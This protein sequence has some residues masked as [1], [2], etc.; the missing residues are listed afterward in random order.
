ME[1][2]FTK[3]RKFS[4]DLDTNL[5][6]I[7][8]L[9]QTNNFYIDNNDNDNDNDNDN[10]DNNDNNI[11]YIDNIED[12]IPDYV[13]EHIPDK[14]LNSEK[15]NINVCGK[16]DDETKNPN[17][18]P[19]NKR[20][21]RNKNKNP[22]KTDKPTY[23]EKD[24][25][26]I[27]DD[28][29]NRTDRDKGDKDKGEQTD[30][31]NKTNQTD[32]T[33][34][35]SNSSRT[36]YSTYTNTNKRSRFEPQQNLNQEQD[37]AEYESYYEDYINSQNKICTNPTCDHTLHIESWYDEHKITISTVNT[38]DDLIFLG[39]FYHC[40]MRVEYNGIDMKILHS[41]KEPLIELN[42]MIGLGKIKEEIVNTII[43][44][45]LTKNLSKEINSDMM[46]AV[47]TGSPGCGKTTFIEILAKVYIGLGVLKK[48][49]IVKTRRSELIGKYLGHTAVQ[50]QKKIEEAHGGILL[51]DEAYALGNP[52]GKD[53]FAKECLDTLNQALSEQKTEFICIIA[54]YKDALDSSFFKYNEGLKRR[55][56]FRYEIEKYTS[57]ELSMI[58]LKKI[59]E[60]GHYGVHKNS[61]W[62]IEFT[63]KQ[64]QNLIKD[65][66]KHFVNQGGDMETLF[67]GAKI[68]QNK[69]VF[70]LEVEEKKKL[71]LSDIKTSVDKFMLLHKLKDSRDDYVLNTMYI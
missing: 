21:K 36:Y 16:S 70:L 17:E 25:R 43:Y 69:R 34:Q 18:R 27:Q 10:N 62:K 47:I 42:N 46:H 23:T 6:E 40:M 65:N 9:M 68:A 26:G 24:N 12:Y 64:L 60:Y 38:L 66:Y 32:K 33:E 1:N 29:P 52:E 41:L 28:K 45:L 22:P 71:L 13:Q 55:F 20:D 35:P 53:S 3:K 57:D 14:E 19:P 44:F 2:T 5:E 31:T 8:H 54:G 58:L 56:P 48:G 4:L 51:I 7:N 59:E 37:W 39:S 67:L 61:I 50:T 49:H 11:Y 30:Q 63:K 15:I